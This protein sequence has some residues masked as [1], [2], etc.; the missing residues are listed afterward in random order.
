MSTEL[1]VVQPFTAPGVALMV[2]KL[3]QAIADV[4]RGD[5]HAFILIEESAAG[6]TVLPVGIDDRYRIIGMIA[7]AVQ[8]L[9][10]AEG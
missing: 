4:E 9:H 5:T 6:V 10:V 7:H 2:S 3:K 8:F 1:H